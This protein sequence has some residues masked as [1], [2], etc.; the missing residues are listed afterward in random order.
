M[1][2]KLKGRK[3]KIRQERNQEK[4][5]ELKG[6]KRRMKEEEKRK[7]DKNGKGV[8]EKMRG[9]IRVRR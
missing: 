9:R 7:E 8:E 6:E 2:E 4:S 1:E 5:P 3:G